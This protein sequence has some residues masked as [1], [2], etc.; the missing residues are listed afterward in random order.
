MCISKDVHNS[1][2]LWLQDVNNVTSRQSRVTIK[3]LKCQTVAARV[4]L[5]KAE[6]LLKFSFLRRKCTY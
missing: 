2:L 6:Y 3:S 1:S 4:T 5:S